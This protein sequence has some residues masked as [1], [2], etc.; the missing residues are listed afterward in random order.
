MPK[1]FHV[2]LSIR[3]ALRRGLWRRTEEGSLVGSLYNGETGV[4][5]SP[6]E[7]FHLLCD[8]LVQGHEM[9]PIGPPCAH[10][11][12]KDGCQGHETDPAA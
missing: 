12:W 9:L 2:G 7:I 1:T 10:W 11:D 3:G 5:L 8:H 4:S 6:D